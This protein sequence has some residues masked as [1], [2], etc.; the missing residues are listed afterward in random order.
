MDG[1]TN[2]KDQPD[3]PWKFKPGETVAPPDAS[4]VPATSP[5][6]SHDANTTEV[7]P[8]PEPVT[9]S[10]TAVPRA[11][12]PDTVTW[13]ASEYIAHHKTPGWYM[14]LLFVAAAVAALVWWLTRDFVSAGVVIVGAVVLAIYGARKPRQQEY[15]MNSQGFS[16]GQR[17]HS[18]NEFRSFSVVPEGAFSSIMFM[19]LK[20][21]SPYASIYYDPADEEKIISFIS[22]H[23][24]YEPRTGDAIDHLVRR[25]RF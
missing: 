3:A 1:S 4:S 20:R 11:D 17:F 6:P 13:T 15:T 22:A 10:F 5:A 25:I 2:H 16:V 21:F 14:L 18:F 24:P 19:P 12:S 23:L 7:A 8:T 9:P